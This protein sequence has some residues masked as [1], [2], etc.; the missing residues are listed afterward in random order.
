MLNFPIGKYVPINSPIHEIDPRAKLIVYIG[1]AVLS[2]FCQSPADFVFIY[3]LF[4]LQAY[5]SN[6]SIKF[7]LRSLKSVY[8]I[9]LFIVFF[10]IFFTPGKVIFQLGSLIATVEGLRN[11]IVLVLRLFGAVLFSTLLSFTTAPLRMAHSIEDL[12]LRM[13][14]SQKVARSVGLVFS[15]SMRFIPILSKEA[16]QIILAQRARGAKFKK[17]GLFPELRTFIAIIVPL[18]VLSIKKADE[19]AV[20]MQVRGFD[21]AQKTSVKQDY[22]QWNLKSSLLCIMAAVAVLFVLLN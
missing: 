6:V 8:L 14:F 9:A 5:L 21:R 13:R 2:F 11:A 18:I 1:M 17:R 7:Y 16:E 4:L 10:Q 15:I 20:A 22:F 19:L 3:A 12:M